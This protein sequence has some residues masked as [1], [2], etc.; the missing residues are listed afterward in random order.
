MGTACHLASRLPL[1]ERAEMDWDPP[2]LSPVSPFFHWSLLATL[3]SKSVSMQI[4]L[5]GF[6]SGEFRLRQWCSWDAK[7]TYCDMKL[8]VFC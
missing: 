1:K 8:D 4:H 5:S 2:H 6:A 7:A 3:S